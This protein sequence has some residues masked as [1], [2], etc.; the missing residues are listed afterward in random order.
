[1]GHVRVRS[2]LATGAVEALVG[3]FA[4]SLAVH[5]S[6]CSHASV[7][8]RLYACEAM[9]KLNGHMFAGFRL[10]VMVM[11]MSMSKCILMLPM[12]MFPVH[13]LSL[14][15]F[16]SILLLISMLTVHLVLTPVSM[17]MLLHVLM[18]TL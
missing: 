6:T 15:I 12:S 18:L 14:S 17:S 11:T 10:A 3:G 8:G 1:M 2:E 16:I 4:T 5:G 9:E 7:C 13:M